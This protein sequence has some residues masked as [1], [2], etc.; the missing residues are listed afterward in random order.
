MY[1]DIRQKLIAS[2]VGI[3]FALGMLILF[4]WWLAL[5][6]YGAMLPFFARVLAA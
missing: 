6:G 5:L 3:L 1:L 2:V 4:P